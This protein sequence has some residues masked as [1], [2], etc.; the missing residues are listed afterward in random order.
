MVLPHALTRLTYRTR[1][2]RNRISRSSTLLHRRLRRHAHGRPRDFA[3]GRIRTARR[4]AISRLRSI[5]TTHVWRLWVPDLLRSSIRYRRTWHHASDTGLGWTCF[6]KRL[7]ICK[8]LRV[9][10]GT[11]GGIACLVLTL[12]RGT[13]HHASDAWLGRTCT[14]NC[15]RSSDLRF[16]TTSPHRGVSRLFLTWLRRTRYDPARR[17]RS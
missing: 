12:L 4:S 2:T 16:V 3:N 11:H 17:A 5:V 6:G 1:R 13:W 14:G 15:S 10:A 7:R 9:A 8:L